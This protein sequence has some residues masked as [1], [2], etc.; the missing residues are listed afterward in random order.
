MNNQPDQVDR[1]GSV[2]IVVRRGRLLVIRRSQAVIAPGAYCFPGGGIEEGE[3]D[4]E[5]L[6]REL[7]EELG[8]DVRPVR[9]IW[10]DITPWRVHLT[11]WFCHLADDAR[12]VANPA[13]VASVHWY[14]PAEMSRL[15]NLLPN[16]RQFLALVASGEIELPL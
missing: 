12:P 2:A 13:E 15:P 7:V 11:W 5:A 14:T 3:T 8:V 10:E 6:V 16:N 4:K 9:Q 1:R